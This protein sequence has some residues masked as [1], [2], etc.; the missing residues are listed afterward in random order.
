MVLPD[1]DEE[2]VGLPA[3]CQLDD[4]VGIA[5]GGQQG[6]PADAKRMPVNA[7]SA[8]R[9]DEGG[10]HGVDEGGAEERLARAK[11]ERS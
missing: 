10:P 2:G 9:L 4:V 3:A 8:A 11:V 7:M 5:R 1:V 6:G